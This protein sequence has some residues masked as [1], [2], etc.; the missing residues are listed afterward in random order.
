[1]KILHIIVTLSFEIHQE[2]TKPVEEIAAIIII[3]TDQE[4]LIG[5]LQ[6]LVNTDNWG[7]KLNKTLG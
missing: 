5:N 7:F 1:M 2:D 6:K 4:N 3:E